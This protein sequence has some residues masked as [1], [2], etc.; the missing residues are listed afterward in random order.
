MKLGL[1]NLMSYQDNPQGIQGVINDMRS[2]VGLAEELGFDTAW[3]AEHHFT[4]YSVSVSPL[5]MAAHMAGHSRRIRLGTAV[6]VLPLYQPMRLAQEIALVDR[7][8]DGRLVLGIGSGYQA[9]EFDRYGVDVE[10]RNR[11]LLEH[12]AMI[13]AAL[14]TGRTHTVSRRGAP[15]TTE[16]L[17]SPL[18]KPLPPLFITTT[19]PQLLGHFQRWRAT[20]FMTAGWRGSP[21]LKTMVDDAR[22]SWREAGLP[23]DTPVAVQQYIHV[24]DSK[25]AALAAAERA[26]FVARMIAALH[27]KGL[28][29]EGAFIKAPA[30]AG[31]PEAS[32]V[33]DNLIIGD[34][35]YV[36]E[37]IIREV[38]DLNP[39][40]Y[41]CFFQFGD[42]PIHDARQSLQKFGLEVIP[43]L[44]KALGKVTVNS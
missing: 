40:H 16:F 23:A 21:R 32:T 43:L 6:I 25:R 33:R 22:R 9:Y 30:F 34:A 38:K 2:M 31:E 19:N 10:E 1:F 35:H 26:L 15:M 5:L 4:N 11:L 8:T 7:L 39:S 41:N 28:A 44:E 13:E 12:W 36:A 3:F 37:R 18:Q 14:T 27:D 42:M 17:L 20:A 24:T 29:T